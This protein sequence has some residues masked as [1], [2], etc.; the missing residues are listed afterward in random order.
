MNTNEIFVTFFQPRKEWLSLE[1]GARADFIRR[2]VVEIDDL[3]GRGIEIV[4]FAENRTSTVNRIEFDFFCVY[5]VRDQRAQSEFDRLVQAS[6]WH[7]Y[8]DQVAGTG[9]AQ[10]PAEI[11]NKLA[12]LTK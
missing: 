9:R 5:S 4:A 8:F 7:D 6:G 2:V 3:S 11:L 1:T 10:A 12:M